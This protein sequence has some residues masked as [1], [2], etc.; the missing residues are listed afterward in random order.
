[1]GALLNLECFVSFSLNPLPFY[2]LNFGVKAWEKDEIT[3][4]LLNFKY[5]FKTS[6]E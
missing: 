3:T 2:N 6:S 4:V 1:M 5:K